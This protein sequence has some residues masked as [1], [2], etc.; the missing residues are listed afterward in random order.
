MSSYEN[1]DENLNQTGLIST[2]EAT[3]YFEI[4]IEEGSKDLGDMLNRLSTELPLLTRRLIES[5]PHDIPT[6]IVDG[7]IIVEDRLGRYFGERLFE[8]GVH[9]ES[10]LDLR[11]RNNSFLEF[12]PT[13]KSVVEEG[14]PSN[15][16]V[17]LF[18]S[19]SRYT[20]HGFLRFCQLHLDQFDPIIIDPEGYSSFIEGVSRYGTIEQNNLAD[21]S[22]SMGMTT[23]LLDFVKLDG[24]AKK[25]SFIPLHKV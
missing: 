12:S 15:G 21:N 24:S 16:S 1:I 6:S 13:Y 4:L 5:I 9:A 2:E 17:V 8:L 10:I 18:G 19:V 7:E 14:V 3:L 11:V 23:L 20:S 22:V 25:K